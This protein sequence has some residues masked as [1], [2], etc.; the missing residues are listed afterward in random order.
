[1]NLM[2]KDYSRLRALRSRGLTITEIANEMGRSRGSIAGMLRRSMGWGQI[3]PISHERRSALAADAA[4]RWWSRRSPAER[5][6]RMARIR[7]AAR[8]ALEAMS[9]DAR[10]RQT[11]ASRAIITANARAR[12]EAKFY[13]LDRT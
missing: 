7:P 1:M 10:L 6:E 4:A 12:R 3:S 9:L 2:A 5:Q 8:I 11:E 13:G